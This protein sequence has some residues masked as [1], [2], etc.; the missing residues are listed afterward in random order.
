MAYDKPEQLKLLPGRKPIIQIAERPILQP[1]QIITQPNMTSKVLSKGKSAFS[2]RSIQHED[3]VIQVPKFMIPKI[4]SEHVKKT[5]S[6]DDS[7]TRSKTRNEMPDIRGE[8][9]V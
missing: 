8:K 1:L 5:L 3:Q 6:Q 9:P 4:V 7:I 2:E